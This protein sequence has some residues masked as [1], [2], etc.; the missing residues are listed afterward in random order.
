MD[1]P[2]RGRLTIDSHSPRLLSSPSSPGDRPSLQ[3]A[4]EIYYPGAPHGITATY[5]DQLNADLLAFIKGR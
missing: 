2:G 5:Q 4:K 3:G 1:G